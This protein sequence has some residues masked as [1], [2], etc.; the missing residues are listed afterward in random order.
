MRQLQARLQIALAARLRLCTE[1]VL[2]ELR[3]ARLG[4]GRVFQKAL[5]A[6]LQRGQTQRAQRGL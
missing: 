2:Q 1:S 4:F 3:I 6:R 5:Q